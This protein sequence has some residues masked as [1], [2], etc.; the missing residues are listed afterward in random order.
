[1]FHKFNKH[2]FRQTINNLKHHLGRGYH[3]VKNIAG[4]IDHSFH[5]A[6]EAYRILE[7]VIRDY[8]SHHSANV[9]NNHAMKAISGYEHIKNNNKPF[10]IPFMLNALF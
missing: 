6:K 2:Q 10:A 3:H 4:H 5:V 7:P 8:A 1:M 9:V